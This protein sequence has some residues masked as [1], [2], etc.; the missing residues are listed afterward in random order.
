MRLIEYSPALFPH[1]R[2]AAELMSGVLSLRHQ[3]FVDYYYATSDWCKLHMVVDGS[4][5]VLGTIGVDKMRFQCGS[6]E[7]TLGFGSNFHSLK[8]G[9]GGYLF[10]KWIKS[11][12]G[13]LVFGG[14]DDT[15]AILKGHGGALVKPVSVYYMNRPYGEGA[16][17]SWLRAGARW[18]LKRSLH[19]SISKHR[20]RIDAKALEEIS[21][22]EEQTYS[23]DLLP[24]TSPFSFRFAPRLDYLSWRYNPRLSFVRYRIFRI[25]RRALTEGY[26]VL[27]DSPE[28][29]IVAHC[30]GEDPRSL[31]YGVL[32]SLMEASAEERRPRPI[33]LTSCHPEMQTIYES[34]GFKSER[35]RRPLALASVAAAPGLLTDTSSWLVNFDW[36]DNGLRAPFL[37]SPRG[38]PRNVNNPVDAIGKF[39]QSGRAANNPDQT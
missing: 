39:Q 13:G 38:G 14:S 16:E 11:C 1:L 17:G 28:R 4:E 33:L 12:D 35:E 9:L 30:D 6:T 10:A 2:Q 22:L 19:K 31:A 18:L 20:S 15:H 32:L 37:D 21:V 23:E 24:R 3:S 29:L 36:G 27:N 5:A 7:L 8:P 25:M 26:V 34:I